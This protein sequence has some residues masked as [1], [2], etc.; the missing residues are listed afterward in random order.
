MSNEENTKPRIFLFEGTDG[1]GKDYHI[2]KLMTKY[3]KLFMEIRFP[4]D[5]VRETL[6][7][8]QNN[9]NHQNIDH[10]K[11]YN[12]VFLADFISMQ[13]YIRHVLEQLPDRTLI[14][15]RY[16]FSSLAYARL[17]INKYYANGR[18]TKEAFP[19]WNEYVE[20][21]YYPILDTI[22]QPDNCI[23]LNGRFA[24]K[25][26]DKRYEV[27]ELL[28]IQELYEEEMDHYNNRRIS[29]NKPTIH[30]SFVESHMPNN[31]TFDSIELLFTQYGIIPRPENPE[32]ASEA[33]KKE[34]D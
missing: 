5:R 6:K 33:C 15:N 9:M 10:I 11:L 18:A 27:D 1:V 13:A 14:L 32:M 20:Q 29:M 3:P 19:Q 34:N 12:N 26:D 4:T 16:F 31:K 24:K 22:I 2:H 23:Y 28:T 7:M 25:T 8:M 17:D 21:H 30:L